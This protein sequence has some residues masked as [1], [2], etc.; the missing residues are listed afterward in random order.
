MLYILTICGLGGED[1]SKFELR[2]VRMIPNNFLVVL[3]WCAHNPDR[4]IPAGTGR[5]NFSS[6]VWW[7]G[8]PGGDSTWWHQPLALSSDPGQSNSFGL[9]ADLPNSATLRPSPPLLRVYLF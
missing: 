9:M 2:V 1:D 4:Q 5:H 3:S 7:D 6:Q 8:L